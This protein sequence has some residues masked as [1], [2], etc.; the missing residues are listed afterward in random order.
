[1]PIIA[2]LIGFSIYHFIYLSFSKDE[3]VK[4]RKAIKHIGLGLSAGLALPSFLTSCSKDDPGPEV[5]FDGNVVVIGAGASGL[6]AADILRSKGIQVTILEAGSQAGGRVRSLRNQ[7][8][9][10]NLSAA[11]FPVEL[12]AEVVEG[13]D[14]LWGIGLK[15]RALPVV[16]VSTAGTDRFILDSIAKPGS[17]WET[18]GDF[19]SAQNFVNGI[20]NYV[21]PFVSIEDAASG[22]PAR[23]EALV[24]SQAG[25]YYGSSNATVG[26]AGVAESLSARQHDKQQLVIQTN[27]MQDF[28]LSRFDQ[29]KDLIKLNTPV[30]SIDYNG[31][32]IVITDAN[33]EQMEAKKVV[34]TVPVSILKSSSINFS[35]GLPSSMTSAMSRI[36]MDPS[37]RVV[38]DF[39]KNFWGESAG[40]IWGG[41]SFPHCFNAGV[42]R[43]E[44]FKTLSITI[45]GAKA[46]E[47]SAMGADMVNVI[48]AE[49]DAVY[50]GQATQFVRRDLDTNQV[51]SIIQDWSKEEY[52]KGG[53]SYPLPNATLADREA[54][55]Q[56][57]KEKLFF[58]GEATDI[59]GDSGTV[60]GALASAER[61]AEQVIKSITG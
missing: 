49:L 16:D 28:L 46:A 21:G 55:G 51:I 36:G 58:A 56:P 57:I 11:D 18:D 33:G 14:S 7:K 9:L 32:T 8:E 4:R 15:N 43:S 59:S 29:V 22:L 39:K 1:M 5:P 53:I 52:I 6:F 25:N 44:F 24:N 30:T 34:V 38:I 47:L 3:H 35:P 41:T 27:P 12:G 37:I 19:V 13:S 54:L 60:N 61:V 10:V 31:D 17:E 23:V 40:F 48:L 2:Y 42:G 20:P 45:N 50:G 26:I